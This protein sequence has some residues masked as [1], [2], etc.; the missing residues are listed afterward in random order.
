MLKNYA[1]VLPYLF[2]L[3]LN[4]VVV[5]VV[6]LIFRI[7]RKIRINRNSPFFSLSEWMG[8]FDSRNAFMSLAITL[9]L[10]NTASVSLTNIVENLDEL[11][12]LVKELNA[13]SNQ[14]A[15]QGRTAISNFPEFKERATKMLKEVD[16]VDS[17]E[18]KVALFWPMFGADFGK[19]FK[20]FLKER[21]R[22][23][24]FNDKNENEFYYYLYRRINHN[25]P[26]DLLLLDYR[27]NGIKASELNRFICALGSYKIKG[28]D[29][30][31][32][33]FFD[34]RIVPEID[35][36]VVDHIERQILPKLKTHANIR[37]R[38][39]QNLPVLLFIVNRKI[40]G[41]PDEKKVLLFIGNV[42]MLESQSKQGGFY[43][44]DEK[45]FKVLNDFYN[46]LYKKAEEING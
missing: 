28:E 35:G 19:E 38:L 34:K 17:S 25:M 24:L 21:E 5:F 15:L 33:N 9:A 11:R 1:F 42:D 27:N 36:F 43:T 41:A 26:T 30:K 12:A 13:T 10:A 3:L 32:F 40:E 2:Q 7:Y 31:D 37:L 16:Q 4:I 20:V 8:S 44:E 45:M 22:L 6:V 18:V 46:S 39:T 29:G 23:P 14:L